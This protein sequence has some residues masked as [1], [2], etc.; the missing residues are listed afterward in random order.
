MI[1][2]SDHLSIDDVDI[3]VF[4]GQISTFLNGIRFSY[5]KKTWLRILHKKLTSVVNIVNESQ[6]A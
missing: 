6:E 5:K 1:K 4:E 2:T 3:W